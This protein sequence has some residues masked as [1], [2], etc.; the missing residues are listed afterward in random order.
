M[1]GHLISCR[2]QS[3]ENDNNLSILN[4]LMYIIRELEKL[5]TA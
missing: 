5:S 2:K 4:Y 1:Y 3:A